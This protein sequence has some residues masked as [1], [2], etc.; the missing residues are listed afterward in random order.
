MELRKKK[1]LC[2]FIPL[3]IIQKTHRFFAFL[4]LGVKHVCKDHELTEEVYEVL[5]K[6]LWDEPTKVCKTGC[7]GILTVL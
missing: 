2:Y 5:E 6:R 7:S 3:W 1:C 4:S